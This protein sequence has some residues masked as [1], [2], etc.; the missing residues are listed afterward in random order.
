MLTTNIVRETLLAGSVKVDSVFELQTDTKVNKKGVESPVY[1]RIK[2]EGKE[3]ANVVNDEQSLELLAAL[4]LVTW[5][6]PKGDKTA[7]RIFRTPTMTGES[8][9]VI[10]CL[11][12]RYSLPASLRQAERADDVSQIVRKLSANWPM[13]VFADI[14]PSMRKFFVTPAKDGQEMSERTKAINAALASV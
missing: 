6:T 14:Q 8:A 9:V 10:L 4:P 2:L 5:S 11:F 1:S 13:D 3:G 7:T 12:G